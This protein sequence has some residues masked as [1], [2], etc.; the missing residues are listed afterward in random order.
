[1]EDIFLSVIIPAY[2]EQFNIIETLNSVFGYLKKQAYS[3]EVIVVNDGSRDKTAD[4][5]REY[6]KSF[7]NLILLDNSINRGKGFAVRQGMQ[8]AR[9]KLALFMDADNSTKITEI[10]KALP[11][12]EQGAEIVIGSRRLKTSQI[13][14]PQPLYRRFLGELFRLTTKFLFGLPYEDTQAGFKIF[15][16]RARQ[17]FERQKIWGW[18]F[19][20]ELL[21]LAKQLGLKVQEIPITWENRR[22]SRVRLRGMIK[23][24]FEFL[25]IYFTHSCPLFSKKIIKS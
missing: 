7:P 12:F 4:L 9:G 2:N 21:V 17:L 6:Q 23:V 25:K 5:V 24:G 22:S 3:F 1:M 10:E 18:S 14:A 19:D 15:N 13:L 11:L 8:Q 16:Q 20:V